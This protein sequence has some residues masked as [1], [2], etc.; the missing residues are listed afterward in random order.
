MAVVLGKG[1]PAM[2]WETL[3]HGVQV[4][5]RRATSVETSHVERAT[6]RILSDYL[7]GKA[8][9]ASFHLPEAEEPSAEDDQYIFGL[10]KFLSSVL[11]F[12]MLADDW[13]G[14]LKDDGT[15]WP[16][17]R[18]SV[19]LLLLSPDQLQEFERLAYRDVWEIRAEGNG[20]AVSPI[21]SGGAA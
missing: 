16:I 19:S 4:H 11:L 8:E 10:S 20:S 9:L 21:G 1:A 7:S 18:A 5:M 13:K 17:D 6:G 15:P 12:E 14:V 2:A 3:P